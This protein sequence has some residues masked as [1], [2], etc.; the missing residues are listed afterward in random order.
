MITLE[1]LML[2]HC[3]T[4][5]LLVDPVTLQIMMANRFAGQ[6]LGYSREVLQTM[7]I[8]DVES[9][10][11]D[12]FYWEDVRNGQY[13]NIEN[14]EGLYQCADDSLLT[15]TKKIQAVTHEG[16][17][18]MLVLA[19]D[20]QNERR[21]ED[22]LEHTLSQLRATL[23]STGN[24]ILVIDWQ[25][26]ISS[27]NRLFSKMWNIP[28]EML[29]ERQDVAILDLM[30]SQVT[31]ADACR[32]H[33]SGI[34]GVDETEAIFQLKDGRVFESRSRPQHLG[35]HIVGRV[36]GFDDITAAKLA[37][38]ALRDS[39]DRLEERV[40]E[41][42][43]D[44]RAANQRLEEKKLQQEALIGKLEAAQNQLLQSE[45]MASIGQLAA[46][47]AHEINNPVGFVNSN[48]GTLQ[49]Y[50][51]GML[52]LLAAYESIEVSA[53][54]SALQE[55]SR[56][57]QEID[58]QFLSEDIGSLLDESL[59]GLDRVKRIVQDLKNFSHVDKQEYELASLEAGLD[60]TLNVVWNELKY[61]A[62]VIKEY[63]GIPQIECLP[64]QLNQVFMNLLINAA[65]AIESQGQIIV[66]TGQD[67]T[68]IWV[69]VEDSG[70]GIPPENLER[71]FE[72]FFTT[73]PVGKGTG[74][75]LS[76]AYGIVAKHGGCIK[77]SSEL[78][79][80]SIFR[81]V[82]PLNPHF[83]ESAES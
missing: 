17:Q 22:T 58:I 81:V 18:L 35:E 51:N 1:Q 69:E 46:G 76:L 66:R 47:V 55:I 70:K 77:V 30:V 2:D 62:K 38:Q 3:P 56:L 31:E 25:G 44:L 73:K 5:M 28:E 57:K 75:G 59:D 65:H 45:K 80:G 83:A 6:R 41:R 11:Q 63:A 10:L 33:L 78:G 52:R 67:A 71:I 29:Q 60:S 15:V 23:E 12:V 16:C 13:Q 32:S 34:L 79:K 64:S 82:L 49:R 19:R 68:H 48:L 9:S 72:P 4:M 43:T 20:I 54:D 14:Q 53:D 74:L 27:M 24:G 26:K 42:T 61:K 40:L 36:F 37:E 21:V 7:S 8:T 50:V 39:R